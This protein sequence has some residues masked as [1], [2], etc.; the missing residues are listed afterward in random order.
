MNELLTH[1]QQ[2][3]FPEW[4]GREL[5]TLD[6][7]R[8]A[9][10]FTAERVAH[11]AA[12]YQGLVAALAEGLGTRQIARAF[13][14]SPHVVALI[15]EKESQDIATLKEAFAIKAGR[16]VHL[17]LER[18]E[19]KLLDPHA[20]LDLLQLS[21]VVEKLSD[22]WLL[23][24]GE[25]TQRIAIERGLGERLRAQLEAELIDITPRAPDSE[26]GGNA[27]NPAPNGPPD[28]A[29]VSRGVNPGPASVPPGPP[30][31]PAPAPAPGGAGGARERAGGQ[32]DQLVDPEKFSGNGPAT[33][34]D[35]A[36]P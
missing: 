25:A 26:S 28:R 15:R 4:E 23:L 32:N 1:E 10:R 33:N 36:N 19:E 5:L 20:K 13:K 3:L 9:G 31:P 34:D 21:V 16:Q 24:K 6:A 7:D 22:K 17:A 2:A 30:A 35:H 14:V 29:G 8:K 18:I 11:N 12:R 27:G